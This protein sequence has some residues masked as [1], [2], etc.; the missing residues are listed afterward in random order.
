MTNYRGK[1]SRFKIIN[2]SIPVIGPQG[3]TEAFKVD[4]MS[5][6]CVSNCQLCCKFGIWIIR[7]RSWL[8]K[9][10]EGS[11]KARPIAVRINRR[12]KI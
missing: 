4:E 7:A 9:K 1:N 5:Q 2:G 6:V 12:A 8:Q 10:L 11:Q 3:A